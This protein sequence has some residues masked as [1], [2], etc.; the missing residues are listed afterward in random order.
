M[1]ST[2]YN[3][4]FGFRASP[5]GLTPDPHFFYFNSIY[6]EALAT[7]SYGMEARRGFIVVTGETGTGKTTLLRKVMRAMEPK[8]KSAYIFNTLVS[9]VD[10]LRLILADLGLPA[11]ADNKLA[12]INQLNEYLLEQHRQGNIVAVLIDEAQDL[13]LEVLE[14]LRLLTN[15]E[16]DREK[17]LQIALVGQPSLER[18]LNE[19][20]LR[21][22]AQRV[23]LRC[24]LTSLAPN[25]VGS[26]MQSRLQA[27]A[28]RTEDLFDNEAVEKI[29]G[30]SNGIPRLVNIIC[31]NALL[32][33]YAASK[34]KIDG[35]M[36]DE[37]ADDLLLRQAQPG[38][39]IARSQIQTRPE[40]KV[41][42]GSVPHQITDRT[43]SS[44]M[45][46]D[47]DTVPSA[48]SHDSQ[49]QSRKHKRP[50]WQQIG[51]AAAVVV[52]VGLAGLLYTDRA[53]LL[54]RDSGR[55]EVSGAQNRINGAKL[56]H[57]SEQ[58]DASAIHLSPVSAPP[59]EPAL[60]GKKSVD[61][62]ENATTVQTA[63]ESLPAQK[64]EKPSTAKDDGRVAQRPPAENKQENRPVGN[65]DVVQASFVR[66]KPT[67]NAD[68]ISTLEPG[69]H[70]VVTRWNGEYYWVRSLG[71]E[72]IRGY[73]HRED[74]FFQQSK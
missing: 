35:A 53:A 15:L 11:G 33:C 42:N 46:L 64:I 28:Q 70:I 19:P 69:T 17:L 60:E 52:V 48:G 26:Y 38:R 22:L 62:F 13:S 65:F 30:F 61:T 23:A 6:R 24:R 31:D 71:M 14:E 59:E 44:D 74:A 16:T 21:Q 8:Y 56:S 29:A 18:K 9:F 36:I 47:K 72:P 40:K 34:A 45:A 2:I 58:P 57:I 5:F 1:R 7:L 66:N 68:I 4:H 63:A 12:M 73:V 41:I 67:A 3:A 50:R 25:E 10:L 54:V 32:L 39:E 51:V 43:A 20:Q 55:V 27:V 49:S 37:V